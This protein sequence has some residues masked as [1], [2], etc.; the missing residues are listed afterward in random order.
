MAHIKRDSDQRRYAEWPNVPG[1]RAVRA[2][3]GGAMS[4]SSDHTGAR[5]AIPV[6]TEL[7]LRHGLSEREVLVRRANG[8]G[9]T[10][11]APTSRSYRQIILENVFTFI[12]LCLFGLGIALAALG[13][14]LDALVSTAVI[15]LNIVVSVVQEIRAKRTLDEI[16]LLSR[17]TATVLR[18]GQERHVSPDELVV[19]DVVKIGPGDQIVVD[20]RVL[21]A[22]HIAVDESLLTGEADIV[23][24]Q[25]GDTVY[26]GSFCV[27]GE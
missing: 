16:A 21:S 18:D 8:Q 4:S 12:N 13:R 10:A 3:A 14:I 20:G 22:E 2:E 19:G 15:S 24:K 7:V 23:A 25:P 6:A 26:S 17:P 11:P 27:T 1:Q 9:N 5:A